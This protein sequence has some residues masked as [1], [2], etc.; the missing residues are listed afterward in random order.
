V[1]ADHAAVGD[2][3]AIVEHHIVRQVDR[4]M[5]R[6]GIGEQALDLRGP[7][8]DVDVREDHAAAARKQRALAVGDV[9]HNGRQYVGVENQV[10]A[11]R[12]C[13]V[14]LRAHRRVLQLQHVAGIALR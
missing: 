8:A 3:I 4:Q 6:V 9:D 11:A 12:P 2:V 13:L 14:E 10:V 1:I 7:P 5:R